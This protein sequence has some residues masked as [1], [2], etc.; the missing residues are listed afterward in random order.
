[1]HPR[2]RELLDFLAEQRALLRT[3]FDEVPAPLRNAAPVP[4]QWSPAEVIEHISIANRRIAKLLSKKIAEAKS[5]GLGAD[6]S[7]E[8]VLPTLDIAMML[9]R[10]RRLTAPEIVLPK[11]LSADIAWAE[12]EQSTIAVREAIAQGDGLALSE[13]RYPHPLLG[14]LSLYEWIALVGAHE[15]RH[16]QQ[17]REVFSAH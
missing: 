3:A 15:G 17:I 11:G 13:I 14:P 2:T 7:T 5:A 16:A 6:A 12:L 4:G 1:M 9:D 10:S 8:P